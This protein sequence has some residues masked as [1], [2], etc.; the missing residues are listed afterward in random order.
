MHSFFKADNNLESQF[1][2]D[3]NKAAKF[4]KLVLKYENVQW[5]SQKVVQEALRRFKWLHF[6]QLANLHTSDENRIAEYFKD[7]WHCIPVPL[8]EC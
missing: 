2:V 1:N 3:L 4:S 8:A 5:F 7:R 6:H